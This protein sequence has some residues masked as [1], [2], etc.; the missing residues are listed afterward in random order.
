MQETYRH[1]H[2]PKKDPSKFRFRSITHRQKTALNKIENR[3]DKF[4]A[5]LKEICPKS[6]MLELAFKDIKRALERCRAA[7]LFNWPTV[8]DKGSN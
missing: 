3:A 2:L 6:D 8:Q 5:E 7:V 1:P 4:K